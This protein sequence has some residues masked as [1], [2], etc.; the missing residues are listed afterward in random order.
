MKTNRT[1]RRLAVEE[2]ARQISALGT[3]VNPRGADRRVA[4]HEAAHAV[5]AAR[6]DLPID[7]CD[8]TE[9]R[10]RSGRTTLEPEADVNKEGFATVAAAGTVVE[11]DLRTRFWIIAPRAPAA[12][13]VQRLLEIAEDLGIIAD[14]NGEQSPEFGAWARV[15]ARE[16]RDL[17]CRDHGAAW[18]RVT[19]ALLRARCL[20]GPA[21]YALVYPGGATTTAMTTERAARGPNG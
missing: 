7:T 5:V 10:D 8:I 1:A 15:K 17:L 6:L 20:S 14:Q 19:T 21:I 13:D 2:A 9:Q 12:T 18:R 16:A 4:R 3:A 11:C